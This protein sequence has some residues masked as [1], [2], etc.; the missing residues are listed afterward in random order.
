MSFN[1]GNLIGKVFHLPK[2][3]DGKWKWIPDKINPL[4][5]LGN[6]DEDE[7]PDWYRPDKTWRKLWW[8]WRNPLH[9]F[10][11]Y[12]I[13]VKDKVTDNPDDWENDESTWEN[14]T[15]WRKTY[16]IYKPTGKKYPFWHY[17]GKSKEFYFGWRSDSGMFGISFRNK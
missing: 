10:N 3:T 15:G 12:V 9:N 11:A 5:W 6:K 14:F 16:L 7:P 8:R 2:T 17:K 13:G 1:L 4:F